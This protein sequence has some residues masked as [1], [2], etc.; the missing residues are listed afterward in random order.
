MSTLCAIKSM[1]MMQLSSKHMAND[2]RASEAGAVRFAN[3]MPAAPDPDVPALTGVGSDSISNMSVD[4]LDVVDA[5]VCSVE[6][7]CKS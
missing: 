1:N 7:P 2:S 5:G 6:I 4:S 3:E